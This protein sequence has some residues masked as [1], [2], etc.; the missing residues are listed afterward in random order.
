MKSVSS[1]SRVCVVKK[2]GIP[3][4][5]P[6]LNREDTAVV[7]DGVPFES[8]LDAL[9]EFLVFYDEDLKVIWANCA[10]ASDS[11][12][13]FAEMVGRSFFEVTCKVEKP[14]EACPV[15]KGLSSESAEVIENNM[16]VGRLFYTRSY[17]VFQNGEKISGRLF[18][19]QDISGLKSRYGVTEI[20]NLIS[21]LFH[22]HSELPAICEVLIRNIVGRFGYPYGV[23]TLCGVTSDEV[24][25][26]GEVD[27][28]GKFPPKAKRLLADR[29][30]FR[31]V[32]Q[33]GGIIK[34]NGLSKIDE[35]GDYIL[36]DSGA[37]TALA[38][39]LKVEEKIIGAIVLVDF[40]ERKEPRPMLDGLQAVATRLA[41]EIHRKQTQER[42]RE[43]RNFTTAILNN[44]GLLVM[45]MDGLGRI[46]RFN[47]AC[48]RLT[49]YSQKAVVGKNAWEVGITT[50]GN[51][52]FKKVF[53]FTKKKVLPAVFENH[54][55]AKSGEKRL[56]SWSNSIMGDPKEAKMHVVSIG[57]D[58]TDK[59]AAEE[60]S[61]LRRRQLVEADKMVSLGVLSSEVAHE[62]NNPNNF[63]MLNAPILR[64]AWEDIS[65]IL[66]K[67]S[68]ECGDFLV[69]NV[70]YSEM[71][72]EVPNLFDGIQE[73]SDRIRQIIKNM[74]SYARRDG[75]DMSRQ[76]DMNV[77]VQAALRLLSTQIQKSAGSIL[78]TFSE[79]LPPIKGSFQRMEQVIVNLVQN[80][81]QSISGREGGISLKTSFD[82]VQNL[83]VVRI[84]DEGVGIRPEHMAHISDPFFTTKSDVGGTGL[85]LSVCAAIVKEHNGSLDFDSAAGK[86]TRAYLSL[87]VVR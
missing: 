43:E 54:L 35:Y 79:Q 19:A 18:V 50:D 22:S 4:P 11:G 58:I 26:L 24:S 5:I 78:T 32:M 51:D 80:S 74:K 39:P 67:Y 25:V 14:C 57:M 53:P 55:I 6:F 85:G 70:P 77:V 31:K 48:E 87:P 65:F 64:K 2:T 61:E 46:V 40:I 66:N 30:F 49:G 12:L 56:I 72:K 13:G 16:F 73:G 36:K 42:L 27:F 1:S 62:I 20:L 86:G 75:S 84:A 82:S 9:P 15:L 8:L 45:V 33:D 47:K 63:I 52:F 60:E 59:R 76:V 7:K 3:L 29:C 10:A 68:D 28:S 41:L 38:V 44:A 83:V 17:P 37:E 71:S 21:E 81:C 23:I 69:S 34:V